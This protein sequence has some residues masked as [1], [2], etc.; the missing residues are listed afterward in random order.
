LYGARACFGGADVQ[1][2][3][4]RLNHLVNASIDEV[5]YSHSNP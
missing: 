1:N 5:A 3:P 4:T 2:E